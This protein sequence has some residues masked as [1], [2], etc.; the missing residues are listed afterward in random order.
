[1]YDDNQIQ[2]KYGIASLFFVCYYLLFQAWQ[3]IGLIESNK[4][5]LN[6]QA[7]STNMFHFAFLVPLSVVSPPLVVLFPWLRGYPLVEDSVD[8]KTVFSCYFF[9][10]GYALI[11]LIIFS[12]YCDKSQE[13]DPTVTV[14]YFTHT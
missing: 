6:M 11:Q 9:H 7:L 5:N 13:M 8:C 4:L 3:L 12:I 1:M 2:R 10:S 14:N